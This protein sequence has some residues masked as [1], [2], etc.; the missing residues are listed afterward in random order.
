M[1]DELCEA[2]PQRCEHV[3]YTK[4]FIRGNVIIEQHMC[5]QHMPVYFAIKEK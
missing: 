5:V 4:Y 1:S 3:T 2:L